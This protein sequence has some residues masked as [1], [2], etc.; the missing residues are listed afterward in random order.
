MRLEGF[1]KK[2]VLSFGVLATVST[3]AINRDRINSIDK[4]MSNVTNENVLWNEISSIQK[5]YLESKVLSADNCARLDVASRSTDIIESVCKLNHTYSEGACMDKEKFELFIE[6]LCDSKSFSKRVIQIEGK[7]FLKRVTQV[8]VCLPAIISGMIAG[9]YILM[10]AHIG[11][12][13]LR[14]R[15]IV[16]N[17]NEGGIQN[18]GTFLGRRRVYS[19]G[20]DITIV[21]DDTQRSIYSDNTLLDEE[22]LSEES[23]SEES[24]TMD[25]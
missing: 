1:S 14:R 16:R 15:E 9:K 19:G 22:S 7:I 11:I 12:N 3:K 25:S 21:V 10:R 23:L 8:A 18:I 2:A 17:L 4:N 20:S 24:E 6:N 13:R 5:E